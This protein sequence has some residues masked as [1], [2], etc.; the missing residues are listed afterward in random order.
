[1][2]ICLDCLNVF[3]LPKHYVENHGLESPPFENWNGCP[4]CGG[5]FVDAKECTQCE[6]YITSDYI[7]LKD[8]DCICENC[9]KNKNYR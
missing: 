9:F 7:Q 6:N 8:G 1:M 5:T 3:V 2:F 4:K